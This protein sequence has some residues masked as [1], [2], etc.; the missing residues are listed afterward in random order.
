MTFTIA[1]SAQLGQIAQLLSS[2][3]APEISSLRTVVSSSALRT[4]CP[5]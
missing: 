3:F 5:E 1:V 2:P 4:A